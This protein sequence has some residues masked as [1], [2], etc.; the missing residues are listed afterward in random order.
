MRHVVAGKDGTVSASE[1]E[2]LGKE[3]EDG[4][5]EKVFVTRVG[6]SVS[7]HNYS[8]SAYFL[9]SREKDKQ[10]GG[11]TFKEFSEIFSEIPAVVSKEGEVRGKFAQKFYK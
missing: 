3:E 2:R 10:T 8:S 5:K 1:S 4:E 9:R 7:T 11:L 6:G